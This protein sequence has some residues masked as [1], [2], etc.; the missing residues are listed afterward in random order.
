VLFRLLL[1]MLSWSL[2]RVREPA[3][4]EI[5]GRQRHKLQLRRA[6]DFTGRAMDRTLALGIAIGSGFLFPT[7]FQMEVYS[8]LTGERGV[9]MGALAGMMEAQVQ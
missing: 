8:D 4:A 2:P 9:L 3:S 1:L 6:S 5:S 7:T